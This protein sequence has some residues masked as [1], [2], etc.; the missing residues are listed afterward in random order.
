VALHFFDQVVRKPD[1]H[2][3]LSEERFTVETAP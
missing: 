3:A 1:A 2:R